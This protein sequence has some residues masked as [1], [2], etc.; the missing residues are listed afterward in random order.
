MA[1]IAPVLAESRLG[2]V[3]VVLRGGRAKSCS[4]PHPRCHCCCSRPPA[5]ASSWETYFHVFHLQLQEAAVR[6]IGTRNRAAKFIQA[7]IL[8]RAVARVIETDRSCSEAARV[9]I[10]G[11]H[12]QRN[13]DGGHRRRVELAQVQI[14]VPLVCRRA[15]FP[16]PPPRPSL[17]CRSL[18]TIVRC[19]SH[20]RRGER[21]RSA[22]PEC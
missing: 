12:R 15:L 6:L 2:S 22:W 14:V 1:L 9:H 16:A 3:N 11:K 17:P 13:R 5:L 8:Q 19:L 7:E 10:A 21:L 20:A 4:R 18:T